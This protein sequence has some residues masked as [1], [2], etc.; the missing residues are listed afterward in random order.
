M[1]KPE[2]TKVYCSKQLRFFMKELYSSESE[3]IGEYYWNS[4]RKR[5]HKILSHKFTEYR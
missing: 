3:C 1:F 4:F 2:N 5:S